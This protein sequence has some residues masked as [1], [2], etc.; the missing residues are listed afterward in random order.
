M[1]GYN[2]PVI[3]NAHGFFP[4]GSHEQLIQDLDKAMKDEN[5]EKI[6][7]ALA[8]LFMRFPYNQE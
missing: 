2:S 7:A 3:V 8:K 1:V 4:G 6:L 5:K